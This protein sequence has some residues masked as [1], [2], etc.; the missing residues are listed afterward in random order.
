MLYTSEAF[1]N[2]D[3][4]FEQAF[5]ALDPVPPLLCLMQEHP[6]CS[7]IRSL[8]IVYFEAVEKDPASAA[9][10]AST[11][12]SLAKTSSPPTFKGGKFYDLVGDALAGLHFKFLDDEDKPQDYGPHNPHLLE[13]L[14]SGLSLKHGFR[15]TPDMSWAIDYGLKVSRRSKNPENFVVGTCIQL[16]LHGVTITTEMVGRYRKRPK[17]VAK[18]LRAQRKAGIVKD[19]HAIQVL[20]VCNVSH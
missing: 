17:K 20:E 2:A 12:A 9:T 11:L 13:S 18:M 6:T 19:P 5:A 3:H 14:L 10:L 8:V 7:A 4:L 1:P 15:I 16:L